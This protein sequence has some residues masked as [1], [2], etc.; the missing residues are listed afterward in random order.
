MHQRFSTK[1]FSQKKFNDSP[2]AMSKMAMLLFCATALVFIAG[3]YDKAPLSLAVH[4]GSLFRCALQKFA[5][6]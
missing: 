1:S 3:T 6:N 4:F 5:E 2:L